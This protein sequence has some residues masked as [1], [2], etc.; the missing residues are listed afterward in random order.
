MSM[1]HP[2]VMFGLFPLAAYVIGATSFA[3]IIARAHHV[4]L[5]DHGSG[6]V[7][8]TNVARVIGFKWGLLC[9]ILDVLKGFG[10][11]FVAGGVM[12]KFSGDL[13]NATVQAAWL[14][15]AFAAI[16]G[17]IFPFWLRFKGGKGVAT[18]FGVLLGLWPYCT[19]PVLAA[20]GLWILLTWLTR[21]ISLASI[22]GSLAMGPL[23]VGWICLTH[24]WDAVIALWPLALFCLALGLMITACHRSNIVRLLAGTEAKFTDAPKTKDP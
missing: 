6:N 13:P 8:A 7:G 9:F 19:V 14:G 22:L 20:F 5:R 11:V 4:D 16:L 1:D 12:T 23:F 18:G 17:H 3:V 24:G 10:P 2:A 21:Y 15:V